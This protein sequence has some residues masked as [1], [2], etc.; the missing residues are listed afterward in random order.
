MAARALKKLG[1]RAFQPVKV[2]DIWRKPAVSAKNAAK[3][4]KEAITEGRSAVTLSA[5][6]PVGTESRLSVQ[7]G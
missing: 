1:A 6:M 4:K 7:P 2:G 3:L 5:H